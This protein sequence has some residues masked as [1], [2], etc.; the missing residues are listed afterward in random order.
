MINLIILLKTTFN[1]KE[2]NKLIT[3]SIHLVR[4]VLVCVDVLV[5]KEIFSLGKLLITIASLECISTD[6][7]ISSIRPESSN[8]IP[9]NHHQDEVNNRVDDKVLLNCECCT[10]GIDELIWIIPVAPKHIN[11]PDN[12]VEVNNS[13]AE[14]VNP[15]E[16]ISLAVG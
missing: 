12:H 5:L 9:L 6:L 3:R 7:C 15:S 2:V 1:I 4:L 8:D 14:E 11:W 13:L 16:G 10:V